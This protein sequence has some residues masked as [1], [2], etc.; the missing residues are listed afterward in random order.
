[1]ENINSDFIQ[2]VTQVQK[3]ISK[4]KDIREIFT[5]FEDMIA[6]ITKSDFLTLF[7]Y[8]RNKQSLFTYKD[9]G[10]KLEFSMI[11]PDGLLGQCFLTKKPLTYNHIASEK[12]YKI[13][14]DNLSG[15]KLRSQLIVPIVKD[16]NLTGIL[17]VSRFIGNN[18][19]YTR[20]D[21]D[22]ITSL[23]T[24]INEVI[25]RIVNFPKNDNS[26]EVDTKDINQKFEKI[27]Q[28]RAG[29]DEISSTMLFLSNTVHDIRTPANSLYGFLEIL[30][31]QIDDKRLKVF[32]ENAKES[33][34]FINN[35]TD[36]ILE[37]VKESHEI[38][39]SRP[40]TVNSVKFFAQVGD[41]FSAN[42]YKKEVHYVIHISPEIPKEISIDKL[43]L[44]RII[45]N[46]IG[47]AYKFT[48]SKK[49]I[50]FKVLYNKEKKTISIE[51]IDTGLGIDKSR[52]DIIFESFKQAEEDTSKH[53]GGTGLGLAISSKYV[54]DLGGKLELESDLG[55]GSRFYFT[56]PVTVVDE[57]P[58][59]NPCE[60]INKK[61]T[62]LSDNENCTNVRNIRNYLIALGIPQENVI[63]SETL[64]PDTTHLFCFQH[65]LSADVLELADIE[66]MKIV[67]IEEDLFSLNKN[68][69]Y[70]SYNIISENTYYGDKIH[71]AIYS[72]KK[73]KI[74]LADD[75]KINIVLLKAMLET[76]YCDIVD[77]TDGKEAYRMIKEAHVKHEPFDVAFVDEH[78]PNM[79]GSQMMEK[80]RKLENKE[81]LKPIFSIT[82]TGDPSFDNNQH[83][84][85]DL[86][87]TKPFKSSDVKTAF[88]SAVE[89]I[90][91]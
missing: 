64:D 77:T 87:V 13:E 40:T 12:Y 9:N 38:T 15:S 72:G 16:D 62:L 31:E 2:N 21:I 73:A 22:I 1:M 11:N 3:N 61:I 59:Q 70:S 82:I 25:V 71:S 42:M 27:E 49:R 47:N 55:E 29:N 74:L 36:S 18:L 43:K 45:I 46:L 34:A 89:H 33:A 30:E 75:S 41:I 7:I 32:I 14:I 57:T 37:Q 20:R 39:T 10:T 53:F 84:L 80:L 52:Q 51:V 68:S 48:P 78:M 65:K 44:K 4:A 35:L 69:E 60:D 56:V 81:N 24:F 17:R 85:Y 79:T 26:L 91:S 88:R 23:F 50:D 67:L 54:S 5:Y 83:K 58:S 19:H 8:D 63:I 28:N 66:N 76:E 90:N 6:E 86:Q